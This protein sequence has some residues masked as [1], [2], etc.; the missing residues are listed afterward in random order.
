MW[1]V[2][3]TRGGRG[4]LGCRGQCAFFLHLL[5]LA[6]CTHLFACAC[7]KTRCALT[8]FKIA[9]QHRLYGRVSMKAQ[10]ERYQ[11]CIQHHD[12]AQSSRYGLQLLPKRVQGQ[13]EKHFPDQQGLPRRRV[14]RP[15]ASRLQRSDR[16]QNLSS[17][18]DSSC[19]G[20]P[21]MTSR[22][23]INRR[24]TNCR[25]SRLGRAVSC[26]ADFQTSI[27]HISEAREPWCTIQQ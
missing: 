26:R 15:A 10:T 11:A 9:H 25:R 18:P 6:S 17:E 14:G 7:F 20:H 12:M 8:R 3:T 24:M 5:G 21:E 23:S 19:L 1:R 4:E 13:T 2:E 16:A 27:R 22:T